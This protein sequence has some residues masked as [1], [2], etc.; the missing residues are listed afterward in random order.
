MLVVVE[1]DVVDV[2]VGAVVEVEEGWSVGGALD[3][4]GGGSSAGTV[5]VDDEVVVDVVVGGAVVVVV[6]RM[7]A[8][9]SACCWSV[10]DARLGGGSG[11]TAK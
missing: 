8:T 4:G 11:R 10:R 5:V 7:R 9:S 1:V 6:L 2:E 3:G